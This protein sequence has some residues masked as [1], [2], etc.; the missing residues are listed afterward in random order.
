MYEIDEIITKYNLVGANNGM[1]R[2][3]QKVLEVEQ[4][5]AKKVESLFALF[6][7]K[8]NKK[9]ILD[10]IHNNKIF[11][12]ECLTYP[13]FP[14]QSVPLMMF[15]L[16]YQ[17]YAPNRMCALFSEQH[18][19]PIE[20][21]RKAHGCLF[22]KQNYK[23]RN[24]TIKCNGDLCRSIS[25]FDP[26]FEQLGESNLK[27]LIQCNKEK[28]QKYAKSKKCPIMGSKTNLEFDHRMCVSACREM[29]IPPAVIRNDTSNMEINKNF[30]LLSRAI[31]DKKREACLKCLNGGLI[32]VLDWAKKK[33][34]EGVF[35][36]KWEGDCTKCFWHDIEG[37]CNK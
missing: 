21:L 1:R 29:G 36:S 7:E 27:N 30:Q 6:K 33:Q 5:M 11:T 22:R 23:T 3:I 35:P 8:S 17:R 9:N 19:K 25:G 12:V 16:C 13:W 14:M 28:L 4:Q 32:N 15:I 31:N 37:A 20:T 18:A 2:N 24:F 34:K 10:R 26:T